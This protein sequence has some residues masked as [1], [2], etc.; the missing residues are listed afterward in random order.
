[1][2][3]KRTYETAVKWFSW[4]CKTYGLDPLADG[5]VLSHKE[6]HE[7]GLASGHGAPEHLWQESEH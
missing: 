2:V 7:R 6:G 4:L 1:M 5:V 3:V